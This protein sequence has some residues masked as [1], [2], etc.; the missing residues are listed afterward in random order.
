MKMEY[1]NKPIIIINYQDVPH[2]MLKINTNFS[3]I[4]KEVT[5][6]IIV[7]IIQILLL[8]VQWK[9]KFYLIA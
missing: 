6:I 7:Q 1:T 2:K 4:N 5:V 8:K 9:M 3:I